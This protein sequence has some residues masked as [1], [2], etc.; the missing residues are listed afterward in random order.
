MLCNRAVVLM[1][2]NRPEAALK[3]LDLAICINA[4]KP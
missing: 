2:L 1:K 4:F 3:D